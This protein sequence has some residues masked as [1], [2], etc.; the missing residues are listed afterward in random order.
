LP[1]SNKYTL[2]YFGDKRGVGWCSNFVSWCAN[3][4]GLPLLKDKDAAPVPDDALLV[5]NEAKV[6]NTQRAYRNAERFTDVPRPGYEIIYGVLGS[7]SSTH[8]GLVESVTD[9]GDGEYELTTL[10]G[11]VSNTVKRYCFRY[12]LNPTR[13]YHN[14]KTVP[15]ALQTRTDAQYKLHKDDWYVTGFGQT[16]K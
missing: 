1:R 6:P 16:W 4:A 3:E 12:L 10:E 15:K 9:L 13:K 7:T 5:T 11:N 2:W 14:F 8:V